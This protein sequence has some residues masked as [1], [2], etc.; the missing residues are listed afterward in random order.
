MP[1]DCI[2]SLKG[3][4]PVTLEH[5]SMHCSLNGPP[6]RHQS[7]NSLSA[8][9]LLSLA[10]PAKR[11]WH[12]SI[13]CHSLHALNEFT[14]L[15]FRDCHY[16]SIPITIFMFLI[17]PYRYEAMVYT[18][19]LHFKVCLRDHPFVQIFRC[20]V[21]F[22]F[23]FFSAPFVYY[24]NEFSGNFSTAMLNRVPLPASPRMQLSN[25]NILNCDANY[26][27]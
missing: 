9:R 15:S 13:W 17:S 3:L 4:E 10:Y 18:C 14:F 20:V 27:L 26:D 1:C 11:N 7:P 24:F 25:R 8:S 16:S 19:S 5:P 21:L 12:S 6:L 23:L 22:L 2:E